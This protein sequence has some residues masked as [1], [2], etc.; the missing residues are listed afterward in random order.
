MLVNWN[1]SPG[2]IFAPP[3][4]GD[5]C[6]EVQLESKERT[7]ATSVSSYEII[8]F[9]LCFD[10]V[11]EQRILIADIELAVRDDGMGPGWFVGSISLNG[12][13]NQPGPIPSSRYSFRLGSIRTIGPSSV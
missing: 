4:A 5:S 2:E 8:R 6:A 12:P 10:V 13:T 3:E 11:T 9:L 7:A 1:M